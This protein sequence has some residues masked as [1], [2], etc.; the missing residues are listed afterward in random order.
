MNIYRCHILNLL[1]GLLIAALLFTML[2]PKA[3]ADTVLPPVINLSDMRYYDADTEVISG[4]FPGLLVIPSKPSAYID[5]KYRRSYHSTCHV[6]ML[7]NASGSSGAPT[8]RRRF[9]VSGPNSESLPLI[10]N[11]ARLLLLLYNERRARMRADHP[12]N[13]PVVNVWLTDQDEKGIVSDLGGEQ[14][15]NQIYLFNV[16]KMRRPVEWAREIAHE[17]GHYALPGITGFTQPEEFANGVL[18]ERLFLKWLNEDLRAGKLKI[19]SLPLV[20]PDQLDEYI[21][22]QVTPLVNLIAQKNWDISQLKRS[23][24][25]GMDY[26]T[27][28]ALYID[29]I[30]GSRVL[31]DAM[32]ET[33]SPTSSRLSRAVDFW[34]GMIS[35]LRDETMFTVTP[36]QAAPGKQSITEIFL[37]AGKFQISRQGPAHSW[38]FGAE[39]RPIKLHLSD[40]IVVRQPAWYKLVVIGDLESDRPFQLTFRKSQLP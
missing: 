6:Y 35:T 15:G 28:L 33:H 5:G 31:V 2:A 17:Y 34:L 25:A 37:P 40:Q 4:D 12:L 39:P 21:L 8:Y 16:R 18:G 20:S 23:D 19:D 29:T 9:V 22:R 24:S 27:A 30:Y 11:T 1:A 3:C 10:K 7:E 26:Y 13:Q 32:A 36:L 38:R 14:F